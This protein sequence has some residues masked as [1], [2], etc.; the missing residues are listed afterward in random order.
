LAV[1]VI[2][3]SATEIFTYTSSGEMRHTSAR[4]STQ[5]A[6]TIPRRRSGEAR[7]ED[8]RRGPMIPS[9][10]LTVPE[11]STQRYVFLGGRDDADLV[12]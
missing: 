2:A 10:R 11:K 12:P 4:S 9:D 5:Y 1:A 7:H 8:Q 3:G 6:A